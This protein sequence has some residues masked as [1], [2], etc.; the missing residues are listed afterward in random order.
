MDYDKLLL[1]FID[2][3]YKYVLTYI[4]SAEESLTVDR[5][6]TVFQVSN[7][8]IPGRKIKSRRIGNASS[9]TGHLA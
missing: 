9:S 6:L 8:A 2:Q 7:G 1:L 4:R 5:T 3:R